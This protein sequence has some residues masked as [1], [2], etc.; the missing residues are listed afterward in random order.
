MSTGPMPSTLSLPFKNISTEFA[1]APVCVH[2]L[3]TKAD[4]RPVDPTTTKLEA[5]VQAHDSVFLCVRPAV[6]GHCRS[7][8]GCPAFP[9]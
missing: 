2:D 4:T 5:T 3:Y 1:T 7:F 9:L 8:E 6:D